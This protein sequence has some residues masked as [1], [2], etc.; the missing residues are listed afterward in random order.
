MEDD[1]V[2]EGEELNRGERG[3]FFVST[4][5]DS[6]VWKLDLGRENVG[7]WEVRFQLILSKIV[8]V[9]RWQEP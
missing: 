6:H 2:V 4:L 9:G 8:V 5:H 3:G 1:A 7:F